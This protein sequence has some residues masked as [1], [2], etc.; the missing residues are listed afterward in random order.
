MDSAPPGAS[1]QP[2]PRTAESS[3]NPPPPP[4]PFHLWR[5]RLQRRVRS[6]FSAASGARGKWDT[7]SAE[8][9]RA[10]TAVV[11][12]LVQLKQL[13]GKDVGA[14]G[15][16]G[17][18]IETAAEK[19]ARLM[20]EDLSALH[21]SLNDLIAAVDSLR[22]ALLPICHPPHMPP[23]PESPKSTALCS[24]ETKS[25]PVPSPAPT[26]A[27]SPSQFRSASATSVSSSPSAAVWDE[28]EAWQESRMYPDEAIFSTLPFTAFESWALGIAGMFRR[29]LMVKRLIVASL[30]AAVSLHTSSTHTTSTHTTTGITTCRG[31][32][33]IPA[34][35]L[36]CTGSQ[37]AAV[38]PS[39]VAAHPAAAADPAVAAIQTTGVVT[40]QGASAG[41]CRIGAAEADSG[42][43]T[44]QA[45]ATRET[46]AAATEAAP[47]EAAGCP[48]GEDIVIGGEREGRGHEKHVNGG[49]AMLEAH[50]GGG[51]HGWGEGF[52]LAKGCEWAVAQQ[53]LQRS[54]MLDCSPTPQQLQVCLVAWLV[55]VHVESRH[56]STIFAAVDDEVKSTA[57]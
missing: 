54:G 38:P 49:N 10:A 23:S 47:R 6:A 36:P 34:L 33:N 37:P 43:S 19:I 45:A 53:Q 20:E 26:P 29:E 21:R 5:R 24:E 39:E 51:G 27:P 32:L 12:R 3:Q 9:L 2:P 28:N 56:L 18:L 46:A 40:E 42:V 48:C 57:V 31:P 22:P 55:E 25:A 16:M 8:G 4:L 44:S 15:G 11:N 1:A 52:G 13:P 7:A 17:G 50:M 41:G 35:V 14:L 30:T